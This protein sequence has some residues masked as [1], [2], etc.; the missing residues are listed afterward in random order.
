MAECPAA[1]ARGGDELVKRN[2]RR[3][4]QRVSGVLLCLCAALTSV[5]ASAVELRIGLTGA[6]GQV[7]VVAS[8]RLGE[9]LAEETNGELTLAVFPSSQLGRDSEMLQQL[10]IGVLDMH[11]GALRSLTTR[12]PALNAWFTPF[13][14]PDVPSAVRAAETPAAQE[15]LTRMERFGMMGLAYTFGGYRHVL[16]RDTPFATLEDL[17]NKKIRISNFQAALTWY[18]AVG[19]APTPVPLGETYHALQTGVLDGVDIDLDALVNLE[20]QRIGQHLTITNHMIYP[21]VFLV[22]QVTWNS[23]SPQHQEILRR[24]IVEAAEWA[25]TEQ[26]KADAESLA[27]LEAEIDVR[28]L[29]DAEIVFSDAMSN[30]DRR[31]GSEPLVQAFQEQ[32][33]QQL[34]GAP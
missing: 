8:E 9:R 2:N 30:W 34:S 16:M 21:G 32:V 19:A 31:Y 11:L 7:W 26:V 4:L 18:Q 13:L 29:E 6:P 10:E 28:H 12:D 15:M 14:L 23:L 20:M 17:N 1:N 24:L 27:R 25:N 5:S 3:I 33:R 22:S